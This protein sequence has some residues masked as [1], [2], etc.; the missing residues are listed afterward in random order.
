[1]IKGPLSVRHRRNQEGA[2]PL[3]RV[4]LRRGKPAAHRKAILEGIYQ[5][6]LSTFE[7]PVDDRFMVISEHDEPDFSYAQSYLGIAH[8]NDLVIIQITANNTRTVAQKK[9][10]YRKIVENLKADPGVRPE[11]VIINLVEVVKENWS[12][13]NGIAQ[14]AAD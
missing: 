14:Y 13:G 2:M 1:M 11:D 8:T 6:M 3:V 7:V 4:Y 9:A 5:A 12:F 10:F